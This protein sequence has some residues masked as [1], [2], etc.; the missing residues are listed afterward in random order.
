MKSSC[1]HQITSTSSRVSFLLRHPTLLLVY[2]VATHNTN[3]LSGSLIQAS[4]VNYVSLYT[5]PSTNWVANAEQQST[6]LVITLSNAF[7]YSN[8]V[9]TSWFPT[10]FHGLYFQF[11]QPPDMSPPTPQG[12]LSH[13]FTPLPLLTLIPLTSLST[14]IQPPHQT[15]HMDALSQL[16]VLISLSVACLVNLPLILLLPML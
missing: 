15:Q 16:S 9:F 14:L 3:C 11:Y 5:Q 10:D 6:F 1:M 2:V 4:N 7:L 13:N 12:T 8:L